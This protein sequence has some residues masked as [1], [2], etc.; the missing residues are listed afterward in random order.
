MRPVRKSSLH[1]I[2]YVSL[3][4]SVSCR[5]NSENI[6]VVIGEAGE[7]RSYETILTSRTLR[8]GLIDP[9]QTQKPVRILTDDFYS[10]CSPEVSYDGKSM[11]FAGRKGEA[12]PWQIWEM[13][14]ST[15]RIRNITSSEENCLYPAYL[16]GSQVVFSK[17]II[18]DSLK[19]TLSLFKCASDGTAEQRI[20]FTP[21]AWYASTTLADGRILA[22]CSETGSGEPDLMVLRPDG[23]KAELFCKPPFILTGGKAIETPAGQIVFTGKVAKES[24]PELLSV[25]YNRPSHNTYTQSTKLNGDFISVSTAPSG[26]MLVCFRNNPGEKYRLC[27]FYFEEG[28]VKILYENPDLDVIEAVM[29]GEKPEPRKLPSE[30]DMLVKTGLLLCQDVSFPSGVKIAKV[31]VAGIESSYGTFVPEADGSFYLKVI[32]DMPFRLKTYDMKGEVVSECN[33]MTLRPNERR[34]CTGC[35]EDPE[36]VPENRIPDAVRKS[37]VIIPVELSE[38]KEKIIE[39]E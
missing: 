28:D 18:N 2:L 22:K 17:M 24:E 20:T 9:A 26:K 34:G 27:E 6:I 29:T 35:H 23:T 16:P 10:A 11:I 15:S 21:A 8:I 13:N 19:S 31:E 25:S 33:W 32:A 39:L 37:P 7:A 38:I 36:V 5:N 12:D 1:I 14:L 4:Y 30:V 3:L